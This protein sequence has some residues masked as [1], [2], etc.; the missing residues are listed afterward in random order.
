MSWLEMFRKSLQRCDFE[1]E[2]QIDA[3]IGVRL[4]EFLIV[5]YKFSIPF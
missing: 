2:M 5:R 1:M 3:G 4:M